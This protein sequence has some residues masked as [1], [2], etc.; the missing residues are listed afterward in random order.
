VILSYFESSLSFEVNILPFLFICWVYPLSSTHCI[1]PDLKFT[2]KIKLISF[3]YP[4]MFGTL[5]A[6][7]QGLWHPNGPRLSANAIVRDMRMI[8]ILANKLS[9][10]ITFRGI[11]KYM[12]GI[13]NKMHIHITGAILLKMCGSGLMLA[14][15]CGLGPPNCRP[16]SSIFQ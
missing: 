8:S 11:D 3:W 16:G 5:D 13:N 4:N 15:S 14:E 1:P 10:N 9:I 2:Y 7:Y 12:R 6:C